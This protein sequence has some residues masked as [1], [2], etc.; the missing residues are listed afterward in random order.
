MKVCEGG[1]K[2]SKIFK[3]ERNTILWDKNTKSEFMEF[4][5]F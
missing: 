4:S 3:V 2:C 5:T 1:G